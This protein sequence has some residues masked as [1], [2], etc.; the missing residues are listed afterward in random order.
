MKS[1]EGHKEVLSITVG[2]NESAKFWLSVLNELKN[3]GVRDIFV[4]CADGLSGIS[5][6]ISAAFPMTEYGRTTSYPIYDVL[7]QAAFHRGAEFPP[8]FHWGIWVLQ[9]FKCSVRRLNKE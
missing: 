5:E 1:E 4:L 2:D 7:L 3:R 6:A 8:A 9:R